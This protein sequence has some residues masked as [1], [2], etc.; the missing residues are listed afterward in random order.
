M[1]YSN[2]REAFRQAFVTAWQKHLK[3]LPTDNVETQLIQII[4]IH[5]EYQILFEKPADY[6]NQ[7]FNLEENPFLHM[8]L[9]LAV[10]EQIR[11]NRPYGIAEIQQ[12]LITRFRNMHAVEHCMM[13]CLAQLM[14]KAQQSGMLPNETDYLEAL[15]NL[16]HSHPGGDPSVY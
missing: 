15:K 8:G 2:D 13:D 1:I 5:P 16:C 7:E 14:W 9:H 11:I 12:N 4:L 3:K 6:E 10:R